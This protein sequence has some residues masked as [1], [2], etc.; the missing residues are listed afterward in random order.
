M[1]QRR[2]DGEDGLVGNEPINVDPR[3]WSVGFGHSDS[4]V[5]SEGAELNY[6]AWIPAQSIERLTIILRFTRTTRRTCSLSSLS[7]KILLVIV[8]FHLGD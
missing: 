6:I 5:R 7:C 3:Y 2:V 4:E 8:I 1:R